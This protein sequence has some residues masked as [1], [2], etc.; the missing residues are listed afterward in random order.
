MSLNFLFLACSPGPGKTSAAHFELVNQSGETVS[1]TQFQNK[2][3]ALTFLYTSCPDT[4]PLYVAKMN[5]AMDLIPAIQNKVSVIVITVDP[6][7]DTVETLRT[8]TGRWPSNW[9][10]LTGSM[11]KLKSVWDNYGIFVQ[12]QEM[13]STGHI[14]HMSYGVTHTAKVVLID[15]RGNTVTELRGNWEATELAQKMDAI[16]ADQ[17]VSG[18][19]LGQ[20]VISFLF[21]CGSIAFQNLGQAVTH[22]VTLLGLLGALAIVAVVLWR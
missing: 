21:N 17:P 10:Y 16:A 1:L 6:E 18:P 7:R 3:V 14:G 22:A 8:Y 9:L 4:C 13:E 5:Q 12:K 20:T 19:S 15:A 11:E 2:T